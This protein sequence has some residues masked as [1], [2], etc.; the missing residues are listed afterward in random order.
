MPVDRYSGLAAVLEAIRNEEGITQPVLAD[1]AGLGRSVVAERVA[2]LESAG[3]VRIAG[4]GP[5]T[6]GRAPRQIRLASDAGYVA[7]VDIATSELVIA[8]ADL[9]GRTLVRRHVEMDVGDGPAV[10]LDRARGLLEE[11]AAERGGM[12]RLLAIGVGLPLPVAFDTGSPV[13]VPAMADWSGYPVRQYFASH[14]QVPVWV[15]NRVNLLALGEMW[16]NPRA[17]H[18]RQLL[19]VGAGASI[20][21]ALVVDGRL[22]RGAHGLAGAIAHVAVAEAGIT[23]CQCGRV[24]CLD[25]IAGGAAIAR[26]GRI[27]AESGQSPLLVDALKRNAK[28]RAVDV[29]LAAEGGDTP[30]LNLLRR[31]CV[32][33]GGSLA[34][35]VSFFAPELVIIGGGLARAGL[36]A[37]DPITEAIQERMLP[38]AAADLRVELSEVDEEVAG[39]VG[40]AQLALGQLFSRENLPQLIE[41]RQGLALLHEST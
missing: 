28:I 19:Y 38:I 40:G 18:A 15:D 3:L 17:A 20:A 21:A 36:M 35:L 11:A 14:C 25:T 31:T 4:L 13:A 6:G 41:S 12:G 9:S 7:G 34:T 10:V 33:L 1:R 23:A 2:E 22:Y 26:Q 30:A 32:S 5:S 27:L 24:G 37:L 16:S 29:T 8:V 39:A